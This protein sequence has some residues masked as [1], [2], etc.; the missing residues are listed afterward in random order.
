MGAKDVPILSGGQA[1]GSVPNPGGGGGGSSKTPGGSGSG[2]GSGSGGGGYSSSGGGGGYNYAAEARKARR[3]AAQAARDRAHTLQLQADA[4]QLALDK[5][6][7]R[8]L[9]KRLRNVTTATSKQDR[10]LMQS[11]R[12]RLGDLREQSAENDTAANDQA[13]AALSNAGRERRNASEQAMAAG[14][15]ETDLLRAQGA[16]LRAWDSN[17]SEVARAHRD[18]LMSINANKGD[19]V[20]DTKTGRANI[21]QSG[22]DR[23]ES[24]WTEYYNDRAEAHVQLGNIY[25]QMANEYTAAIE[26]GGGKKDRK[27]RKRAQQQLKDAW[28][29]SAKDQGKVWK[30]P[31][32]PKRIMRW[33]GAGDIKDSYQSQE[34]G[35]T[36]QL[37]TLAA[38]APAPEGASLRK[39]TV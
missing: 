31:G 37:G 2:S 8:A 23:R 4:W 18:S 27:R 12:S 17:Q 11:Y 36:N 33:K 29:E 30:N 6:F 38:G 21:A 14:A 32:V 19:L 13:F 10:I 9:K 15:G 22:N 24:L 25:G 20:A 39:W 5:T 35:V 28:E 26:S 7:G 1:G 16:A 3:K 34:G